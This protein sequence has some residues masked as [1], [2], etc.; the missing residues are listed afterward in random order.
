MAIEEAEA[1]MDGEYDVHDVGGFPAAG[2]LEFA[3]DAAPIG[4]K[5]KV[6]VGSFETLGLSPNIFRGVKRKGYQVPTPIQRKTLPLI[7]AGHDVVAMARTGSG[8]TAA[9]LVPMLEKLQAHSPKA[10]SRAVILSPTRE[11]ALQTFKFTKELGR[12]TDLRTAVLVGGDSMEAQFEE[13]SKNPD[14]LVTTPGRLMHHL[15]EVEGMSLRSV[16]YVVFDEA[17]RLFEMGFAEQL[18]QILQ[19]MSDSRQTLLFSATLPKLLAEFARAGLKDPQ[20][21]RLDTD[22]KISPDLQMAFF[23]MRQDE[24]PAAL[25]HLLREVIP[26]DQQSIIFVSTKHHVEYIN[27]LL[28]A[29]GINPSVVY[30]AMDQAARKIHIAKFRARKTFLLVVTDVAARGI[31]IPLLNN[32]INY[33]FP[34]KPKLFVHRVG[35]AARAGRVGTAYSLLTTD[36]LPFLLDLHLFMSRPVKPAPTEDE[37]EVS[38]GAALVTMENAVARGETVFGRFPQPALDMGME[39][40]RELAESS[41]PLA[42]IQ[43]VCIKAFRLYSKTRPAASAESV[44]RSKKLP[45]E[46]L[47]PLLRKEVDSTEAAAAAFAEHLKK[48]RPK[49]TVLEAEADSSK[50]KKRKATAPMGVDV[51]RQKRAVHEGAIAAKALRAAEEAPSLAQAADEAEMAEILAERARDAAEQ[52]KEAK[53]PKAKKKRKQQELSEPDAVAEQN[54]KALRTFRDEDNY[55]SGIPLNRFS[56]KSLSVKGGEG[57]S[58]HRMDAEVLDLVPDDGEGVQKQRSSYVWDKKHKKYVKL[59]AGESMSASGKVCIQPLQNCPRSRQRVEPN[60]MLET[61]AFTRNGRSAVTCVCLPLARLPI[62]RM[63]IMEVGIRA[64]AVVAPVG[65]EGGDLFLMQTCVMNYV[66]LMK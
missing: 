20:L 65:E 37:I 47:H 12:Y 57:W 10:G 5:K 23:T 36:E 50:S 21:I 7:L 46:G 40:V 52:A 6:R 17:D 15:S 45:R 31:D 43:P 9:F 54:L 8:K 48:F 3:P 42:L 63:V 14:I 53:S 24:K 62:L 32:V 35:R 41:G 1:A 39:R 34:P 56:E 26:A 2:V 38:Q 30:G 64:V 51:M 19:H 27:E 58:G 49:Q 18:R 11:L 4:K 16:E 13:L 22:T 66:V 55:I 61:E 44:Q 59:H 28:K 29:E 33:D 60:S 25:L